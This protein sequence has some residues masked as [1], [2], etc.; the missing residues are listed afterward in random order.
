MVKLRFGDTETFWGKTVCSNCHRR[1]SGANVMNH[2]V[3][4]WMVIGTRL[5]YSRKLLECGI[6]GQC[7]SSELQDRTR[8]NSKCGHTLGVKLSD[9][10]KE[11][12]VLHI[13]KEGEVT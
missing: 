5:D 12:I 13:H 11:T 9:S 1:S 4:N 10:V 2:R 7:R 3:L 8:G 6:E